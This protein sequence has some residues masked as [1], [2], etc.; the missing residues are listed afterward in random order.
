MKL[1]K[2]GARAAIPEE[3]LLCLEPWT[4]EIFE[5]EKISFGLDKTNNVLQTTTRKANRKADILDTQTDDY[6]F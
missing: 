6:G 1:F 3:V 2:N 4:F 5:L